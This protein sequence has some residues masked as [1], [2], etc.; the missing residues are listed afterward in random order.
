MPKKPLNTSLHLFPFAEIITLRQ[1]CFSLL[2]LLDEN[3]RH[4]QGTVSFSKLQFD[5]YPTILQNLHI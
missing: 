3:L 4:S 1:V 5:L 2:I